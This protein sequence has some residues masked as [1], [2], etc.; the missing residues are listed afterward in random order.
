[1]EISVRKFALAVVLAGIWMNISEFVRNEL[2]IKQCWV[3]GFQEL[4]LTY[5]SDPATGAIWALWAFVFVAFVVWLTTKFNLIKSTII[6][7]V[8][9]FVLLWLAMWNLGVLPKGILYWAVPW[10]FVEVYIVAIIAK[11]VLTA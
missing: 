9:G 11:R 6:A 5:P 4:G 7:W 8:L 1:M 10:S 2:V 3:D